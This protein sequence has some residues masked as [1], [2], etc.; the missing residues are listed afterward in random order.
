RAARNTPQRFGTGTGA[1]RAPHRACDGAGSRAP[2]GMNL[3]TFTASSAS[4][5][6]DDEDMKARVSALLSGLA[7]LPREGP[8]DS[9]WASKRLGDLRG[10]S[11]EDEDSEAPW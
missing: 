1:P 4:L 3:A 2:N 6:Q 5:G 11:S 8:A 7:V 9:E 10:G